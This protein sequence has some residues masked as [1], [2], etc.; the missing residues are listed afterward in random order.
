M[1]L[2]L[3]IFVDCYRLHVAAVAVT[4][5]LG[6]QMRESFNRRRQLFIVRLQRMSSSDMMRC[7]C[8]QNYAE[9]NYEYS[10]RLEFEHRAR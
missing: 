7:K 3:L 5:V 2:I 1:P 10:L 9:I 6:R 8:P 4:R